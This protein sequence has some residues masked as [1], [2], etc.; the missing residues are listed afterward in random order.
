MVPA[1]GREPEGDGELVLG[2]RHRGEV[3]GLD[4]T[5][6]GIGEPAGDLLGR[7]AE[8]PMRLGSRRNSSSW[9]AKS[10]TS[11]RPPGATRRLASRTPGRIVEV[12]QHL[13]HH[14]EIEAAAAEGRCVDV[15]LAQIDPRQAIRSRLARATDSMAWLESSP[16]AR[17]ARGARRPSIRPVPVP[18]SIRLW[19]GRGPSASS[20]AASTAVSGTW[21]ERR[22]SHFGARRARSSALPPRAA[23]VPPRAGHDPPRAVA[24]ADQ[25]PRSADRRGRPGPRAGGRTPTHLPDDARSSPP[26]RGASGD[27]RCGAATDRG[28]R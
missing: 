11:R 12:M 1:L 21:S 28:Y 8:A 26:R 18:R 6:A 24:P 22:W 14:N 2:L 5:E 23:P 17:A 27:A 19:I 20:T 4:G 9:G 25:G 16:V 13:M 15:A 7:E 3:A 10:T